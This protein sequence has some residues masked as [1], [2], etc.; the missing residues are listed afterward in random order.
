M[1][2]FKLGEKTFY[3]SGYLIGPKIVLTCAHNLYDDEEKIN[4]KDVKFSPAAEGTNGRTYNAKF[5]Y[6]PEE[7]KNLNKKDRNEYDFG[8]IELGVDL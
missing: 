6:F 7:Y 3:G 2:N 1:V 8:I 5:V 4:Y